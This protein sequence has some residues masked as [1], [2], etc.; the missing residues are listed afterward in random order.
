MLAT[1]KANESAIESADGRFAIR[2]STG[3]DGSGLVS[4]GA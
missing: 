4:M 3:R 2:E 1:A